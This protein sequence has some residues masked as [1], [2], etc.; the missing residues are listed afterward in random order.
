[1]EYLKTFE[2]YK[3]ENGSKRLGLYKDADDHNVKK[4]LTS[5]EYKYTEAA[6]HPDSI[7]HKINQ[8]SDK[9]L[10]KLPKII[11]DIRSNDKV[12][13]Y[14]DLETIQNYHHKGVLLC[15]FLDNKGEPVSFHINGVAHYGW[16]TPELIGQELIVTKDLWINEK[17]FNEMISSEE[18]QSPETLRETCESLLGISFLTNSDNFSWVDVD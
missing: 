12:I 8:L 2:S 1:M 16:F 7:R 5:I 10:G 6:Q 14:V 4:S 15:R 9:F 17:D 3:R 13:P 18:I 11:Q